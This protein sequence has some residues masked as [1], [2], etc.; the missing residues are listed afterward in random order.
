VTSQTSKKTPTPEPGPQTNPLLWVR[1][2]LSELR[3]LRAAPALKIPRRKKLQPPKVSWRSAF[4]GAR[5]AVRSGISAEDFLQHRL[6]QHLATLPVPPS[7]LPI[8]IAVEDGG[9]I[10]ARNSPAPRPRAPWLDSF[11]RAEG[12]AALGPEIQLAQADSARLAARIEAQRKRVDEVT[13]ELEDATR[14]TEVADPA[15]EAQAQHMGRPQVPPPLGLGLQLFAL[16][17]LLAETWQLAVPCLEGA[18]IR[19]SDLAGELRRTPM[20]L[21][22]GSIFALGA[23]ASLFLFAHLSLRRGLELFQAQAE[24]RRRLLTALAAAAAALLA[25]AMAWSIAGIRPGASHA[26]AVAYARWTLFL[27][28]L[29]V[30]AATAWMLHLARDLDALRAEALMKARAWDHEHYRSFAELS[31]RGAALGEE[32]HRLA[33]LEADRAAAVRRLRALQQRGMAAQRLAADAADQDEQELA[34]VGQSIAAALELD[35]YEYVRQTTARGG[36]VEHP[37][38]V[39][40]PPATATPQQAVHGAH[41]AQHNLGLAS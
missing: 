32:E 15:D 27:I 41:D 6:S 16:A 38:R 11:L 35:R 37:A 23:S 3:T 5:L 7:R 31:R 20:G 22:L 19:T 34:R 10:A 26:V 18:G 2:R 13:R 30:P 33:R 24:P 39:S 9:V 8:T 36:Q 28:A 40:S 17:L 4:W 25:A 12:P 14:G 29:A 21:V 1:E